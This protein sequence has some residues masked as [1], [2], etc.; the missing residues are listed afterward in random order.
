[1][2]IA[3]SRPDY[4]T[5]LLSPTML[6][7]NKQLKF[8]PNLNQKSKS[9]LFSQ[10]KNYSQSASVL[11]NSKSTLT[12]KNSC[13]A[14]QNS[15]IASHLLQPKMSKR[16]FK[17]RETPF[18]KPSAAK[19]KVPNNVK[20]EIIINDSTFAAL[21]KNPT[22][23]YISI[24]DQISFYKMPSGY[25]SYDDSENIVCIYGPTV[26]DTAL[27]TINTCQILRHQVLQH[28]EEFKEKNIDISEM[29]FCYRLRIVVHPHYA[30][31]LMD[32][33]QYEWDKYTQGKGVIQWLYLGGKFDRIFRRM[34]IPRILMCHGSIDEVDN[35]MRRYWGW[36]F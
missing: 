31:Q 1:M 6:H 16:Y 10:T 7:L 19:I 14:E 36:V 5:F 15:L 32:K 17:K 3:D 30:K 27:N 29:D 24:K 8:F 34:A 12:L 23:E 25:N 11:F 33:N 28:A 35:L 4:C 22:E 9:L 18:F 13:Q 21:Q 2:E 26:Y 20:M